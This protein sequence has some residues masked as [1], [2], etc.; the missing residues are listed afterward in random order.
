VKVGV[1]FGMVF[2]LRIRVRYLWDTEKKLDW[3]CTNA[4]IELI[5]LDKVKKIEKNSKLHRFLWTRIER[6]KISRK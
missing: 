1:D 3:T 5:V 2:R 4:S 6:K